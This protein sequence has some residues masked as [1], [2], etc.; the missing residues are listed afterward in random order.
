[1]LP[2]AVI[3]LG[4][5]GASLAR[6]AA[7]FGA[8][9]TVFNRTHS[10]TD[11]FMAAHGSEGHF[12]P[13]TSLEQTVQSLASP[14]T[15]LIMVQAGQAVDDTIAALI[16]HLSA[17]DCI[18]DAGNSHFSDSERREKMLKE[19]GIHFLGLGVSGGEEGALNGPSMMA[20]GS[21]EAFVRVQPLL[22]KM[23]ADD[24]GRGKCIAYVGSGGAGHFVK[25]VHNGI[26]YGDMQLIAEAY[27]LLKRVCGLHNEDIAETFR[28][29]NTKKE[30]QSYLIEISE[31]IMRKKD[32]DGSSFIVDAILDRAAQKGTGKWTMQAA[33]DLGISVPTIAAAID[34]RVLSSHKTLRQDVSS[35]LGSLNGLSSRSLSPSAIANALSVGKICSYAQGFS[36]ISAASD[37][38]GWRIPL[39]EV[40][41]IWT[42]GCIIRSSL[43]RRFSQA[44]SQH[45]SIAHLLLDERMRRMIKSKHLSL[46]K[47]VAVGAL[48][49]IPLPALSSSLWYVDS[50][51]TAVLPQ[52]LTQAQRDFFGAHTYE[53][54]DKPGV[55]HT[56]WE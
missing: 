7:R 26:E 35:H 33:L 52:N 37:V 53:R 2:I 31:K 16:P 40:C 39:S 19:R 48:S 1:M 9:V 4:T 34:A 30:L 20:G 29:W 41:R 15:L 55:F 56:Q 44:F 10:K 50:L 28:A 24:A 36:L 14:R 11:A 27:D 13:T 22:S 42:G 38:H 45:P 6:N 12:F 43:L 32:V 54:I 49:G 51:R 25:M 46:R 8:R 3:G 21:E 47:V 5:M 23:A 18:I 17:G